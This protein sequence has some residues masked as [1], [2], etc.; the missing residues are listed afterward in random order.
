MTTSVI[1]SAWFS[2]SRTAPSLN[3]GRAAVAR[4][5]TSKVLPRGHRGHA[6]IIGAAE[7]GPEVGKPLPEAAQPRGD[8]RSRALRLRR[9]RGGHVAR[10]GQQLART[11]DAEPG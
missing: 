1:P 9:R 10:R 6:V 7:R 3:K 2:P 8:A 5:R 11:T 4:A